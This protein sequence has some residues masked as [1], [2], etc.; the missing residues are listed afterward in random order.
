MKKLALILISTL[1]FTTCKK[2][3][4]DYR[5]KYT[6]TYEFTTIASGL[7]FDC[8]FQQQPCC[9]NSKE[10][11]FI[12]NVS[13]GTSKNRVVIEYI[14]EKDFYFTTEGKLEAYISEDGII[15][16]AYRIR[17]ELGIFNRDG[18]V[19]FNI[20]DTYHNTDSTSVT[21]GHQVVGKKIN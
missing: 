7:P 15:E 16:D 3:P 21:Y 20:F 11:N 6:G 8:C 4:F 9:E 19:E 10:I 2:I 13:L 12:G 5:N 17:G 1:F 18:S 14:D